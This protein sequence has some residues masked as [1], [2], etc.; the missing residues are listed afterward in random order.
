MDIKLYINLKK[1]LGSL[2]MFRILK[3]DNDS[4]KT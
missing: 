2:K 3:Q 1:D 4:L